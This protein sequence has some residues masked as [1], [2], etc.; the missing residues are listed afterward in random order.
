[1]KSIERVFHEIEEQNPNWSSYLCFAE[2][3]RV[4]NFKEKTIRSWFHKLV[5]PQDY[6]KD[7]KK[8]ILRF[9]LTF[10]EY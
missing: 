10:K 3:I 8:A 2:T 7:E 6:A 4:R 5:D 9:L 1:M